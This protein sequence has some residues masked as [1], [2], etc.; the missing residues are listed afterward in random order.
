V[1]I[2]PIALLLSLYSIILTPSAVAATACDYPL[3]EQIKNS[4]RVTETL[5]RGG[6]PNKIGAEILVEQGVKTIVN[7]ETLHD[8]RA[9]FEEAKPDNII[10]A[11]IGYFRV[12][13]WEPLV[14][15][16]PHEVDEH[17][18]HFIAITRTQPAPVYVHCRSGENRTGIMVAAYRVF[19]GMAIEDAIAEMERY[20]GLWF[21]W[22]AR[23]IRTLTPERRAELEPEIA[24]WSKRLQSNAQIECAMRSCTLK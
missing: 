23:Y 10:P 2:K 9:T 14:V 17:V 4:C 8:D 12:R 3:N 5:W 21:K 20:N 1:N 22:G 24:A 16:A 13:D 7:L 19:N 11:T 6:K 18:A 15:V